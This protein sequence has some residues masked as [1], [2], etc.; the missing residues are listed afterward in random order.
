MARRSNKSIAEILSAAN[1]PFLDGNDNDKHLTLLEGKISLA[2]EDFTTDNFCKLVLRDRNRLSEENALKMCDYIM[3]MKREV[4]P[5]LSYKRNT[6]Q[7]I[8]ELSKAIG[9][10]KKFIDMTRDDALSDSGMQVRH[11][12]NLIQIDFA[13]DNKN[14]NATIDK[15]EGGRLME[16]LLISNEPAYVGH[17]N[18]VF[19]DRW[20]DSI[21]AMERIGDIEA[22]LDLEHIEVI[23]GSHKAEEKYLNI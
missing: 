14:F 20:K 11:L 13:V 22:G 4:N 10:D 6:I 9:I 7:F 2:T 8:A 3:A 17:Y 5:R 16:S 23:A 21:D 1:M 15:M 12:K 19:E 18:S